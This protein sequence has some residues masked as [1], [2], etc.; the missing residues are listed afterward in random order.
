MSGCA[1]LPNNDPFPNPTMFGLMVLLAF[2]R[3]L[4]LLSVPGTLINDSRWHQDAKTDR[5]SHSK[6]LSWILSAA[7]TYGNVMKCR[8]FSVGRGPHFCTT[9]V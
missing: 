7:G 4:L 3:K 1:C 9:M 6:T 5:M 2:L 8:V